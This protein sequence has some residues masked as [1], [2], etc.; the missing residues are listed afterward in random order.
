MLLLEEPIF[1]R[2]MFADRCSHDLRGIPKVEKTC[3]HYFLGELFELIRVCNP[4]R[5]NFLVGPGVKANL[6]GVGSKDGL[7]WSIESWNGDEVLFKLTKKK[8]VRLQQL[9]IGI[10]TNVPGCGV[11]LLSHQITDI[12][13]SGWQCFFFLGYL[14]VICP[15]LATL[16]VSHL[17]P[18]R[19]RTFLPVLI[20]WCTLCSWVET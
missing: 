16:I 9:R 13:R 2:Q 7:G 10:F 11:T 17:F 12:Y 19:R 3:L 1:C 14:W 8:N 18:G 20:N 6:I 4:F 5:C 15:E